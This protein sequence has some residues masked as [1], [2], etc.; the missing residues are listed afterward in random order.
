M[1]TTFA[2]LVV[3]SRWVVEGAALEPF[4]VVE[5][6]A[7]GV[8]VVW[9]HDGARGLLVDGDELV[10]LPAPPFVAKSTL[11]PS[12]LPDLPASAPCHPLC[13]RQGPHGG[14]CYARE[15]GRASGEAGGE[16][17][18][19]AA[20]ERVQSTVG[21][22]TDPGLDGALAGRPALGNRGGLSASGGAT[23]SRSTP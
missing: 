22:E 18:G 21:G 23:W 9:E 5:R 11:E 12:E 20:S 17:G 7:W 13:V 10:M 1:A 6:D 2:D 15:S 14:T 4:E 19:T 16:D 8:T 3:G